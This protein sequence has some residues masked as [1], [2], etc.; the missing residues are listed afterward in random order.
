MAVE[1]TTPIGETARYE[2]VITK[3]VLGVMPAAVSVGEDGYYRVD[4]ELLHPVP[5]A[6]LTER[7]PKRVTTVRACGRD[8]RAP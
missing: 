5:P 1:S 8:H 2:G 6:A 7:S 3:D 4:Y